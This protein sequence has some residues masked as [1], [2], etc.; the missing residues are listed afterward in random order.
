MKLIVLGSGT[1]DGVPVIGCNCPVC[2]SPE[3]PN[4]RTRASLY[5][6]GEGGERL[7][8]DTGPEFRSQALQAGIT[9]LDAI[10]LTHAHADHLHGLDDVRPL[11]RET[12]LPLY[13]NP[14]TLEELG[15]RF[16]YIFRETQRGGGKPRIMP[17]PARDPFRIGGLTISP[18]P[19]KHGGLDILGWKISED[20]GDETARGETAP[21]AVYLTDTS[22]IPA[23]SLELIRRPDLL[24]IGSLRERPHETHFSF[25]EALS[26]AVEMEARRVYLT[27]L[28]HNHLHG[29]I[30]DYCRLFQRNRSLNTPMAPAHDGLELDL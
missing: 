24:I 19:V 29:E 8:I 22:G 27:H 26:A 11:C 18:V 4:K 14:P 20:K 23:A 21:A 5:V 12:P 10:L 9:R 6:L 13:A 2:R 30:E 15:E 16:S 3:G 7:V 25:E 17:L 28:S 1:S